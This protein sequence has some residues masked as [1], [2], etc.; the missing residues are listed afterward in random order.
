MPIF[1]PWGFPGG[2]VVK[3]QPVK[4]AMQE[5]GVQSLC[6]EYPLKKKMATHS[7]IPAWKNPMDRGTWWGTVHGVAKSWT[8]LSYFTF[9]FTFCTVIC[10]AKENQMEWLGYQNKCGRR[11]SGK[12]GSCHIIESLWCQITHSWD[13][14]IIG[15]FWVGVCHALHLAQKV[16]NL[17]TMWETWVLSLG[18]ENPLE[19]DM[20]THSSI[21]AWRI[22]VDR[23]AW[24][25]TY[26]LWGCK[27]SDM[28]E[29]LNWTELGCRSFSSEEQP[30]LNCMAAV[31]VRSDFGAQE[32][33]VCHCLH[34]FFPIYLPWK[35]WG[36]M[37]WY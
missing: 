37:P 6:C 27:E 24:W 7:S 22:P 36:Q 5:M 29:R 15:S 4:Q 13:R 12:I 19:G 28:T 26:R 8:W 10:L 21:L 30:S 1:S 33:K 25:A 9:T 3:N 14:N 31:T 16:K 34:F 35:W 20:A 17:P 23:G 11:E 2:S 18:W 32:N